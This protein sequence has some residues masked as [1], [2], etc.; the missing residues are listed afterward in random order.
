MNVQN[1]AAA[2]LSEHRVYVTIRGF[3]V[4]QLTPM[5]ELTW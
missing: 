1:L 3:V 4:G 5:Y 2:T